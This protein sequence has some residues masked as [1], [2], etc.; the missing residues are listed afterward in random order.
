MRIFAISDLHLSGTTNKPM[1]I[2][3]GSWAEGYWDRVKKDWTEKVAPEDVVLIGGDI[4]WSM[5]LEGA[6]PDLME[7]DNLPGKK[8]LIRGNHDYWW[9]SLNKMKSL[10][11]RTI[12]FLQNNATKIGNYVFC[13]TRGWTVPEEGAEQ[14]EEDK[15]IFSR[16]ILRLE[17]TLSDGR[18]LLNEG[19]KMI[20]MTHYPPF[21][22]R[23]DH[24]PFTDLMNKYN[25]DLAIYGHLHGN[26]SRYKDIV[27]IDR[28]P[29]FLTSC[30][31]LNNNILKIEI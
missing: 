18:K 6:I 26:L 20:C 21:N 13:G 12:T 19:D 15:K 24:S 27:Y 17:M 22:A 7:I 25:V 31:F 11:L 2:F 5:S 16:E 8:I 9:A 23:F 4:S 14:S 10:L 3:G 30:D 29:Y 28:I 1:A